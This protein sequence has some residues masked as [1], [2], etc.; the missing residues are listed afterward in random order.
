[1]TASFK[2]ATSMAYKK[3]M[4]MCLG[5]AA[6]LSRARSSETKNRSFIVLAMTPNT[7]LATSGLQR[8]SP[9]I[10]CDRVALSPGSGECVRWGL[11]ESLAH[12]CWAG[13]QCVIPEVWSRRR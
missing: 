1:M 10:R 3:K 13:F 8:E 9:Q 12:S 6:A 4:A 5:P 11:I 7:A 2:F